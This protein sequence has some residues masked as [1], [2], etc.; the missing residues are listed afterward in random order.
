MPVAKISIRID[1]QLADE[2][3]KI[4][5]APSRAEA[6]HIALREIVA[7]ERFKRLM[8]KN[9]GEAF[10]RGFW[11]VAAAGFAAAQARVPGPT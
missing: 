4:L 7:R 11:Q 3:V 5:S 8:R 10:L 1:K 2:L 9:A 6:V